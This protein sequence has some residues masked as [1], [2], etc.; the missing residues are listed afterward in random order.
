MSY[1]VDWVA[2]N[3]IIPTSDLTLIAGNHYS[4]DMSS[5]LAE[6]RRLEWSSIDGLWAPS[7]VDHSDTRFDFA[8]ADYAPFDE[9]INGYTIQFSGVA[10][11]VDLLGSNNNIIDALVSSGVSVVPSNSAG[12]IVTSKTQ[13]GG[14]P[15]DSSNIQKT[16]DILEGDH[17]EAFN[18][19]TIFRKG[20]AIKVLDKDIGGSLLTPGVTIT[21][22]EP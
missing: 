22:R 6:I 20:T 5:F 16:L 1:T 2:K 14:D 10:D 18:H 8:G 11:R 4:L 21:T 17:D 13:N 7:I 12:L 15:A 19:V 9:I 3:V